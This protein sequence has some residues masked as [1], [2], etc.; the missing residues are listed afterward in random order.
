MIK[1]D[2]AAAAQAG[3]A[4]CDERVAYGSDPNQ[5][6][7]FRWT[8]NESRP[9]VMMIH[10][11]FWRSRF[12]LSHSAAFCEAITRAGFPTANV[13][14]RRVGQE[15]GGFPGTLSDILAAARFAASRTQAP[16]VVMG[17]SAGGHLALWL[18]GEMPG[19][20]L[21]VGLAPVASLRLCFERNLSNGAVTDF[22]GG[23][24]QTVADRYA[25]ADPACRPARVPR[26]L[27]HGDADDIVPLEL[28]RA[29][30]DARFGDANPPRLIE[31]P[32][33]DH[34][35]VIDPASAAWEA[36][37]ASLHAISL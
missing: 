15:G 10:G 32:G 7:D 34:H 24:P 23:T 2:S 26:V 19:L 31:L 28:S 27:I 18:A 13:E 20:A 4:K 35:A 36:V 37:S 14:Y 30:V 17:H 11:G 9:L 8:H 25:A 29:Y 22:L 33:L 6:L 16:L 3:Q 5:F 12:D 1:P 21:A